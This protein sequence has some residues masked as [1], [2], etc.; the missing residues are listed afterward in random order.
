MEAAR[1]KRESSESHHRASLNFEAAQKKVK[2]Q[3]KKLKGAILK[4]R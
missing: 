3:N 1:L 2:E 4:S